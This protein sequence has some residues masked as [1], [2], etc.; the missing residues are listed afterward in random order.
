MKIDSVELELRIAAC[1]AAMVF[2][3][4]FVRTY[5]DFAQRIVLFAVVSI[6]MYL[7]IVHFEHERLAGAA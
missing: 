1:Y 2:G 6:P 4:T 5:A 3:S 7:L